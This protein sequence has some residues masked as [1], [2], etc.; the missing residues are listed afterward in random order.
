MTSKVTKP[1]TALRLTLC[2]SIFTCACWTLPPA[3]AQAGDRYRTGY[4][5]AESEFGNGTITAPVRQ[6]RKGPQVR[7]P[8]G[9]WVYCER[10]CAHTLRL[11]TVDFWQ[12]EEGAGGKG[13]LTEQPGLLDR[14]LN[15]QR[16][17]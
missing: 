3:Q 4:V 5:T 9:N 17:Y 16:R 2:A 12:S 8:G 13:A 10:T 6:T 1:R 15:W 7:L 14:W 11:K